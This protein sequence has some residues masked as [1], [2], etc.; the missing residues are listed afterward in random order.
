MEATWRE[1]QG[2]QDCRWE[3]EWDVKKKEEE[4]KGGEE[5]EEDREAA[6]DLDD[7]VIRFREEDWAWMG[8]HFG[9]AWRKR[10]FPRRSVSV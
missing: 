10:Y 4:R 5:E 9:E 8:L 3:R 2:G 6:D 7:E 1:P